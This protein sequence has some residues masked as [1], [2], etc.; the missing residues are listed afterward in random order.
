MTLYD[1][2]VDVKKAKALFE[3]ALFTSDNGLADP[4][5]GMFRRVMRSDLA[6]SNNLAAIILL[7]Q[8][9]PVLPL[10]TLW[11]LFFLE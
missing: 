8:V 1:N 4:M 5:E 6:A 11:A 2:T 9:I 3:E 7:G 10:Q